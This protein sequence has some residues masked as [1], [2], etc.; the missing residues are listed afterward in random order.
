MRWSLLQ[1]FR[2][3]SIKSCRDLVCDKSYCTW[4]FMTFQTFLIMFISGD[5]AGHVKLEIWC[6]FFHRRVNNE[7]SMGAL[8]SWKMI[9]LPAKF[10]HTTGHK[11]LSSTFNIYESQ[12]FHQLV[13][14]YPLIDNKYNPRTLQIFCDTCHHQD[15]P[16]APTIRLWWSASSM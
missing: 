2:T 12:Y 10:L 9:C 15:I 8:S 5:C 13:P 7:R 4:T 6:S 1:A 3:D 11:F 14:K 16:V